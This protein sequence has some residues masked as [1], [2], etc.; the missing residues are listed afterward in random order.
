VRPAVTAA[1]AGAGNIP[2][3]ILEDLISTIISILAVVI[4][5]VIACALIIVTAWI[6]WKFQRKQN[7]YTHT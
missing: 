7:F 4:P 1:T 6:V 5:V 2:I 3:S